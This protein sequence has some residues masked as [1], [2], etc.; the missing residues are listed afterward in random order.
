M[1]WQL[2]QLLQIGFIENWITTGKTTLLIKN[3]EKG[4][5]PSNYRAI[6]G[7]LT[8]FKLMPAVIAEKI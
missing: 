4:T 2:N 1:A 5:V 3:K 8:T 6:T 7:L